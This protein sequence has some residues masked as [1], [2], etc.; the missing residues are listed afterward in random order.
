MIQTEQ[1]EK[2]A[3][4][5]SFSPEELRRLVIPLVAEQL[6]AIAVGLADSIMV[7]GVSNAAVSAVS[8]VDSVSNLMIFIFSAFAAGGAVAAG[9]YLGRRDE[10]K[11]RC[12]AEQLVVLLG[13]F[14][15]A[16]MALM[17]LGKS[18]VLHRVF[19][20]IEADV[21]L[22][23]DQYYSVVM[24]SIPFLALY[25]AGA[26]LMRTM[27][28][29]DVTFRV[30]LLM[31]AVNLGGNALLIFGLHMGVLGA[32]IPTLVSRALAAVMILNLFRDKDLPLHLRGLPHYRFNWPMV[33]NI[34]SIAVPSGLENGMFHFGRLILTS[35]ISTFGTASIMANAIGNTIGNFHIFASAAIGLG[36]TT[37][38][39][40]CVGAGDYAAAR[41][42]TRVLL[43]WCF[44][45]QGVINIVL[46]LATPLVLWAYHAEG[47]A[48]YLAAMV[49]TIHG[50]GSIL[51][52]PTAFPLANTLRSAGDARFTMLVTM[53]TMWLCRVLL[54]YVFSVPMGLGVI[55]VY[56]AHMLDWVARSAC[57][58]LRYRGTRWQHAA[59]Q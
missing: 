17:Y 33:R 51:I 34:L 24:A 15:L 16:I 56:V 32:A 40:R 31:N 35:L 58:I 23:T 14:A 11:A 4:G 7:A 57:F 41:K 13:A 18:F 28:R 42:Y 38:A 20:K 39:S 49:M 55:G 10:A 8:L 48:A 3:G 1:P 45:A 50:M 47:E 43:K 54:G 52:Y 37:V 44:I 12:A 9:Q 30:S 2:L 27:Q 46:I 59:L 5:I 21:M 29:S 19:G 36:L 26:A 53:V 22:A 25:N 6:L